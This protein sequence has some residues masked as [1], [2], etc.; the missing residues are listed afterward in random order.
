MLS[1][2]IRES[3]QNCRENRY[4]LGVERQRDEGD[5]SQ[6]T[7]QQDQDRVDK[8]EVHRLTMIFPRNMFTRV[9]R[10]KTKGE[11]TFVVTKSGIL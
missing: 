2:P 1:A 6:A 10:D 9:D 8:F 7:L 3:F 5:A 11:V 4:L